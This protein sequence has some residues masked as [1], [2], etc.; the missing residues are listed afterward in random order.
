DGL[1]TEARG[2]HVAGNE[3]RTASGLLYGSSRLLGVALLFGQIDNRD[4]GPFAGEDH[5]HGTANTR[6]AARDQS[7]T[8]LQLAG[9]FV[10]ARPISGARLEIGLEARL[11]E[12][13]F[14]KGRFRLSVADGHVVVL[15]HSSIKDRAASRE[16]DAWAGSRG[17]RVRP[18]TP[19][20]RIGRRHVGSV[21]QD[22]RRE[23]D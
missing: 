21:Q 7:R 13:L 1:A 5:R 17:N 11:F 9:R 22:H 15:A 4:V 6:I 16:S 20:T 10:G 18:V 2:G 12:R 19:Q 14:W 8:V 23:I 3:Q